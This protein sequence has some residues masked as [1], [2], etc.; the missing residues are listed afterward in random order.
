MF[1]NLF[2]LD[3]THLYKLTFFI[4][5]NLLF[6]KTTINN[7]RLSSFISIRKYLNM[8]MLI[9]VFTFTINTNRRFIR[10]SLFFE[11]LKNSMINFSKQNTIIFSRFFKI[12]YLREIF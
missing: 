1:I 9:R 11:H 5:I 7:K 3:R 2:F 12:I 8:Y 6:L 10:K 4:K